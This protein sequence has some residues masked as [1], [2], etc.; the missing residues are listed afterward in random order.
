MEPKKSVKADL[1]WRK[2]VFFE[3]GLC[4]ALA[5]VL[6]AFEL[7]GP[8]EK[9]EK[10]MVSQTTVVDEETIINTKREELPPPP[11]QEAIKNSSII[12]IIDDNN[13]EFDISDVFDA[14]TDQDDVTEQYQY[15]EDNK[16]EEKE[17]EEI[18]VFVEEMPSFPGG[19]QALYKWLGENM[20]Y[21]TR[22]REA[23][24]YGTVR[25]DFVVEPNGSISHVKVSRGISPLLDE[26]ALRVIKAMPK[27]K[28]G[29]QRNK[30][31]RCAFTLPIE[32][33]LN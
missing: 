24:I 2:P 6:M 14:E 8:K 1:E 12:E 7:V 23:G 11:P 33:M 21:P 25:V 32:F 13:I 3:I 28:P 22:A 17:E 26:E 4:I 31:V 10:A 15:V 29:K 16:E 20:V 18:F 27:W 5:V 9:Q 30:A 19:D